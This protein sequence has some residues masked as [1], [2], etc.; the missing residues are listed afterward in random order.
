MLMTFLYNSS[1]RLYLLAIYLVAPFNPKARLWIK[2][3]E[4]IFERIKDALGSEDRIIWFHAASLGEFEQGRPIIEEIRKKSPEYK[5]LL[6]FFSPSGYEIRKDY[7]GADYIYYLPI[8]TPRNARRFVEIVEPEIVFFIKYE[9][10]FNYIRCLHKKGIPL[11]YVSVIFRKSQHFFKRYGGWFRRK[12]RKVNWFF[13]Q[14]AESLSL[15]ESIGIKKASISGD[16]RFDRVW[17]VTQA[18][19]PFPLVESF[20]G[21]KPVLLAGS[22]WPA[23]EELLKQ[24]INRHAGEFKCI[25]APHEIHPERM[26]ELA[27]CLKV[28]SSYYSLAA[29]GKQEEADLLFIDNIGILLHLY[30]YAR[31]AFIGGGFGK[32]VH[33]I[34]EAATFGKP[35]IFGPKFQKFQEAKDLIELGGAFC[36]RNFEEFEQKVLQ[37]MTQEEYYQQC[38]K[39]CAD[40]VEQHRGGTDIILEKVFGEV[41]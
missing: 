27:G 12:L 31:I 22:S 38:S 35:V 32:S 10:W 4:K 24:L 14:N 39:V 34:L 11:Y 19:K 17:S 36:V 15:I 33:N 21:N 23:D 16:T 13:V 20:I 26:K 25:I 7:K 30:Q 9:F 28:K 6:T 5:I 40:Y 2:G 8:D 18:H 37:L 41:Y 29:N 1:V 3:R